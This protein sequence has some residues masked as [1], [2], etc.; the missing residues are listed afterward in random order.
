VEDLRGVRRAVGVSD[1]PA[2]PPEVTRSLVPSTGAGLALA[3][4]GPP[5]IAWTF[6]NAQVG[7]LLPNVVAQACLLV[8]AV[9]VGCIV[10]FW[11][12]R[13]WTTVGVRPLRL[14]TLGWAALLTATYVFVVA[15][16]MQ[17]TLHALGAGGFEP[18]VRALAA[19][20]RWYRVLIVVLGA[21]VED[22]LY[23]GYAQERLTALARSQLAGAALPS[24][25][26]AF[27]HAP[28]W[29]LGVATA[30]LL[31]GLVG[32]WFY[33]WRRDLAANVLAHMVTDLLGLV[34]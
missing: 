30:L 10:R 32:A 31:P 6:R 5:L 25:I 11:E 20:P 18:T 9:A 29:G 33:A 15:P 23:R 14:A 16:L 1:G 17:S 12:R 24:V 8:L 19:L 13:P 2:A 34:G 22:F 26:F 28:L 4:F 3:L 27:A 7:A 21:T